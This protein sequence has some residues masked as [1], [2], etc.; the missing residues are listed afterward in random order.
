MALPDRKLLCL[1]S[2]LQVKYE[3]LCFVLQTYTF[4]YESEV[5]KELRGLSKGAWVDE[6]PSVLKVSKGHSKWESRL[7]LSFFS[8]LLISIYQTLLLFAS[9]I[10]A[11]LPSLQVK[12]SR[13][14]LHCARG[15]DH[16]QPWGSM[17]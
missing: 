15:L 11:F 16:S 10:P 12:N 9:C 4:A 17:I 5:L 14:I 1:E 8:S 3:S 2:H 13:L 6:I 7:P